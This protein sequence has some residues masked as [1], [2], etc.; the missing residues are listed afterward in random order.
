M[1]ARSLTALPAIEVHRI[2][3]VGRR[4]HDARALPVGSLPTAARSCDLP[5]H[6]AAVRSLPRTGALDRVA[7]EDSAAVT[8][9]DWTSVVTMVNGRTALSD[10][11]TK[12]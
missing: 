12:P 6:E 5:D 2:M 7:G 8:F 4:Y 10:G 3:N 11:R 1:S 9:Q